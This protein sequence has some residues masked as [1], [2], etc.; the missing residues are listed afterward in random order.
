LAYADD[1]NLL[2]DNMDTINEN[3]DTLIDA[4]KE[5]GQEVNVEKT[6]YMLVSRDQHGDQNR[7]IKIGNRSFDNVSEFK[8]LGTT[9]TNQNLIQEEIKRGLI[10]GNVCYHL[11][12]NLLSVRLLQQNIK[13]RIYKT[14]IL[15]V[16]LYGCE[17]LPL[18]LGEEHKLRI[19][20]NRVLR[21]IFGL[22]RDEVKGGWKK[23]DNEGLHD[24]Y[25]SPSIIRI[26]KSRKMKWA[27]HV[28]RMGEKRNVYRFLVGK[29]EGKRPLGRPRCEWINNIKIDLLEIGL[30]V[31]DWIGLA[32]DRNTVMNHRIP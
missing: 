2:G 3:A 17:M 18:T 14:I 9:V 29:L 31:E 30:G 23:L 32:Q 28:A 16:V 26:I 10:S 1:V 4:N 27:V 15:P 8:Y 21:R 12:Q 24:L 19:F 22:K 7:D 25:A 6:K 5:V 13:I 11:V 20:E